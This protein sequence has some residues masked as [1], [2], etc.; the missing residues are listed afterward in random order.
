[1]PDR[2]KQESHMSQ[3]SPELTKLA[4]ANPKDLFPPQAPKC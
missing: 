2:E 1:M 3:A 4:Q